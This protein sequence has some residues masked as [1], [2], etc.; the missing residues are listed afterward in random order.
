[1][2]DEPDLRT[3]VAREL[4][5]EGI[6]M[7]ATPGF[8]L[9]RL[10]RGGPYVAVCVERA[11]QGWRAIVNG[12]AGNWHPDP[13]LAQGVDLAA[14]WGTEVSEGD[15]RLVAERAAWARQYDTDAPEAKPL[16]RYDP[17]TA[18]PIF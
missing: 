16:E 5:R 3:D 15:Y 6:R 18:R 11:E 10:T 17:A 8:F 14:M 2:S 13:A 4:M 7:R 1:M 12:E 9:A